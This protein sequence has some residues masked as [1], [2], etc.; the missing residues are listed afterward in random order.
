[1]EVVLG[2]GDYLRG[3]EELKV[4]PLKER[5]QLLKNDFFRVSNL[6]SLF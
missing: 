5:R 3:L 1:M 6:M 4:E 2:Y